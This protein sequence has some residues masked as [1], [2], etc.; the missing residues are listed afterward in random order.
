MFHF[1]AKTPKLRHGNFI[2]MR[3]AKEKEDEDERH[4]QISSRGQRQHRGRGERKVQ[5]PDRD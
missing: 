5:W 2:F 4:T 3:V 1:W